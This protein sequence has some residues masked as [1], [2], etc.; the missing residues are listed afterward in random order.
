[1][2]TVDAK[3]S[4]DTNSLMDL[5]HL[6]EDIEEGGLPAEALACVG[7]SVC[8]FPCA[9]NAV[10]VSKSTEDLAKMTVIVTAFESAGLIVP[11]TDTETTLLRTQNKVL[12][13]PPLDVE[14]AGQR[15]VCRQ[16]I[17]CTWARSCQR[18]RRYLPELPTDPA[19]VGMLRSFQA[20]AVRYGRC[21]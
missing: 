10:I 5:M 7:K 18:K 8:G 16:R 12:Q 20:G 13:A 11:S 19:H 1:M 4:K 9:G 21:F 3:F 2:C 15:Y 14:A 6:E 17:F